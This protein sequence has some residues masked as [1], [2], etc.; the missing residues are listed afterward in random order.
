MCKILAWI[1]D[2]V[3]QADST[4]E[5]WQ[6]GM[7][8]ITELAIEETPS[9]GTAAKFVQTY[10]NPVSHEVHFEFSIPRGLQYKIEIFDVN[11]RIVKELDG[12][13]GNEIVREVWDRIDVFGNWVNAGVYFYSIQ[14]DIST[15]TGKVVLR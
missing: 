4:Y 6:G 1:Q 14:T 15:M 12:I 7:L 9:A 5:I 10:P 8:P 11:G 3:I 13:S 2:T